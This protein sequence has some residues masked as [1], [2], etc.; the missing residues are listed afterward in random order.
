MATTTAKRFLTDE[1]AQERINKVLCYKAMGCTPAWD[2]WKRFTPE[3]KESFCRQR[4]EWLSKHAPD[5]L[6]SLKEMDRVLTEAAVKRAAA[7]ERGN[8]EFV[9]AAVQQLGTQ[10]PVA[11]PGTTDAGIPELLHGA[12][13]LGYVLVGFA[14]FAAVVC[15]APWIL[16]P[17]VLFCL[18][19][20]KD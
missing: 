16:V 20:N 9:Q 2:Y 18:L 5:R 8:R 10:Q 6:A 19:G 12:M 1:Q 14:V 11:N 3:Q 15:L 7:M 13:N 4:D 17:V